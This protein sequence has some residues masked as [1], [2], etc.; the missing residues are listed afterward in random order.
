MDPLVFVMEIRISIPGPVMWSR[1]KK[2]VQKW[3]P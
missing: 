2:G 3:T 1:E